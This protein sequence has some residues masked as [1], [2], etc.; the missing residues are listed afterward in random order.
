MVKGLLAIWEK[1]AEALLI[2]SAQF[3]QKV[4]QLFLKS[5]NCNQTDINSSMGLY[6]FGVLNF[7]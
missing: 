3:L 5:C 2:F 7:K 1:G 4:S 6:F